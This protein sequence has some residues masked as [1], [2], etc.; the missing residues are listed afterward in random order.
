DY[1]NA[2]AESLTGWSLQEVVGQPLETVFHIVNEQTRQLVENPCSRALKEGVIVGLANHTVL[3]GKDGSERPIDDSAAPI[4]TAAGTV[5]GCVLIFRDVSER[6]RLEA[7]EA[8]R[9]RAASFLAS[10]I[11]S[12]EDAIVSK[13][14]D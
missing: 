9:L 6:R 14:L 12:S 8:K 2:I 3:L 1:M 5:A 13:S 4:K 7:E 11:E 10:I